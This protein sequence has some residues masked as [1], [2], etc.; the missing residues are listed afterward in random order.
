MQSTI[1]RCA[2]AMAGATLALT[3]G[4][5]AVSDDGSDAQP[6]PTSSQSQLL[7]YE[8]SED[9]GSP[10]ALFEGRLTIDERSGYVQGI[11]GENERLGMIFPEGTEI[12]PE[13]TEIRLPSGSTIQIDSDVSLGGG[14]TSTPNT[15]PLPEPGYDEYF[16]VG[17]V[18]E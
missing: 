17:D 14:Y 18:L 3:L 9:N 2:V 16:L 4:G 8:A 1:I 5:C 12:T 10:E 6:G 15:T 11:V 13:G 7:I